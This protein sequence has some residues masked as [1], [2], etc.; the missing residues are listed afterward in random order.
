[1]ELALPIFGLIFAAFCVWLAVRIV[2]R[3]ERWAKWTLA[4]IVGLPVL[5][6]ASFGPAW[7]KIIGPRRVMPGAENDQL[8]RYSRAIYRPIIWAMNDSPSFAGTMDRYCDLWQ[9]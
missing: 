1:M 2:N 5:Y 6:A 7:G 8:L 4:T 3:R 9:E